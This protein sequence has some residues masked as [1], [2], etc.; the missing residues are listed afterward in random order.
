MAGR[1]ILVVDDDPGIVTLIVTMLKK[2]G[3]T[4]VSALTGPQALEQYER[5]RPDLIL[6][7]LAMPGM[8]G[9][10]V[11]KEIRRRD[12]LAGRHT[13]VLLLTA[14]VQS[15]FPANG[16]EADADGY[17]AKPVTASKLRRDLQA[18]FNR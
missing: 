2:D 15:Y 11:L 4:T 13:L 18:I 8:D 3:Y 5:A 9:F 1:T 14:H 17:I 16:R 10:D 7:D 6:L 12:R